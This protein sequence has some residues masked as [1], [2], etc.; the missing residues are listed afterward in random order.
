MPESDNP[1]RTASGVDLSGKQLGDYN[2]LRRLG[3]GAM[4]EVYLAD[5]ISL[6]RQV[7]LKVLKS[8]LASE[9]TCVQRFRREAQAAASLIHANIVQVHEVACIDG[10]HFIA[11]EY[12]QGVNLHQYL[13][14]HG[15]LDLR[16]ALLV[17]R[18][19][20]AALAKAADQKIIHR[21]IKPENIMITRSGEVKVADFGL[22]R[23]LQREGTVQLTQDGMT[24]GTPLYMSPEQAEGKALDH[25]SDIYSL[26]I[27][28]YHVLAGHPPF[29][30]ETALAVAVQHLKKAPEPLENVRPDLPPAL[31]RIIHKMMAKSPDHRHQSARE[32]I[33]ELR[34][35]LQ[36]HLNEDL[37][38]DLPG[39]DTAGLDVINTSLHT[40]TQRLDALMKVRSNSRRQLLEWLGYL[41]A[42]TA[43]FAA[44]GWIAHA[45]IVERP[46]LQGVAE[47]PVVEDMG[48]LQAQV[49]LATKIDDSL[50][51][52]GH[53]AEQAWRSVIN[54]YGNTGD[55]FNIGMARQ[56]LAEI[57]LDRRD[58]D[59]AL[60][61][62][63]E[64]EILAGETEPELKA[65]ALAGQYF[66]FDQQKRP[67]EMAA[68]QEQLIPLLD[69]LRGGP[70]DNTVRA[71]LEKEIRES[72]KKLEATR[73][74]PSPPS[75]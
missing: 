7:A 48:S 73:P 8:E 18:Q 52:D 66:I 68:V 57:Y 42:V 45:T 54:F 61:E 30:G 67:Q 15:T 55:Q 62:Y 21:D 46:L 44:G 17:L 29:T 6:G 28:C 50:P 38:D 75:N 14:R 35:L 58:W 65:T 16:L 22:A 71:R 5:Q 11:Q 10:V 37:G 33:R 13:T 43:A 26:G 69:K 1:T 56:R 59:K 64:L 53:Q 2:V 23:V 24:M 31:A 3:R 51:Y 4:A 63:R 70:F 49:F 19:A 40:A 41:L 27:A 34:P 32:L 72:S 47:L 9:P 60:A 12:V 20:A 74:R 25:R 36:E 39:L